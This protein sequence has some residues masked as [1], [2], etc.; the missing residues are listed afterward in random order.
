MVTGDKW[1]QKKFHSRFVEILPKVVQNS[2]EITSN[3][4]R[5]EDASRCHQLMLTENPPKRVTHFFIFLDV[6]ECSASTPVCDVNANCQN[7]VGSHTCSC[8]TGFTGDGKTCTG[9]GVI[10]R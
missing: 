1:K 6:D 4:K 3:F 8:I 7:T 10:S 5:Y 2:R 9:K